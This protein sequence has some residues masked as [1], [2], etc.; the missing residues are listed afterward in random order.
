MVSCIGNHTFALCVAF[1]FIMSKYTNYFRNVNVLS[2]VFML[3]TLKA[4]AEARW[5]CRV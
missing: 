2:D 5:G 4:C 3:N 1:A